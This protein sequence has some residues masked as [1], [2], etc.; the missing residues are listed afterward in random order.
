VCVTVDYKVG[1]SARSL[2]LSVIKRGCNQGVIRS[3]T[4]H[5]VA[6]TTVHVT[7]L[8][9]VSDK[10]ATPILRVEELKGVL[11]SL[12]KYLPD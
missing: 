5:F 8:A 1:K 3:R 10:P 11:R 12:D 7:I 9:N 4:R 6:R 2:Y